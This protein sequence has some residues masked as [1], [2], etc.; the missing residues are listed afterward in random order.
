MRS[1]IRLCCLASLV[2]LGVITGPAM[3]TPLAV[4]PPL[5]LPP[6]PVPADDPLTPAK[7]AL[8]HKLFFDRRLSRN[9]TISCATCHAP[10]QGFTRN[11]IA[12]AVGIAGQSGRRNAPTL[13][14][15][16]YARLLFHDGRETRLERQ[17]WSPLLSGNEMGNPSVRY[18][19]EKIAAL[20][21]YRGLFESA[22]HHRGPTAQTLGMALAS[23]ER[24]L[25]SADSP[26]DSWY[27]GNEKDAVA[28]A[29]KRGFDLFLGAADCA[30]CHVVG[31]DYAL[32]TD[33]K[34]H[35]TGVGY[36][37]VMTTAAAP[38]RAAPQSFVSP[39][40][41]IVV[42]A[43]EPP[44]DLGRYEITKRREDRWKYKTP[45]LR[46]VALTAPYMHDGSLATLREVVDFYDRG[47]I[48][49]PQLDPSLHPLGLDEKS[50]ED[51][52]AF[53]ESLTGGNASASRT[54]GVPLSAFVSPPS[55]AGAAGTVSGP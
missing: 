36:R 50:K 44:T 17:P 34:L 29:V 40:P 22:F 4:K 19:L 15:V 47:G 28:P 5:G 43:A 41:A 49:N 38:R 14:N 35:N 12:R 2:A 20:A 26:F 1:A 45:S 52:V 37:H 11:G 25:I 13:Y 39:A 31:D 27:F 10:D 32:F 18:V 23:Y 21:D 8:G 54:A 16:A 24:T 55:R 7:V 9:D 6:V 53:L 3:A 42:V 33:Q 48:R 46:N 51:L 30:H